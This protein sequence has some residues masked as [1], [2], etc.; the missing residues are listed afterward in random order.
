MIFHSTI[1][2]VGRGGGVGT[3]ENEVSRVALEQ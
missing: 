3:G 2:G 1:V